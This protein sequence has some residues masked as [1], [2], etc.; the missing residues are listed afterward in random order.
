MTANVPEVK[1]KY[2]YFLQNSVRSVEGQPQNYKLATYTIKYSD[3]SE[4]QIPIHDGVE[5]RKWWTGQWYDNSGAKSWP[6]FVGRNSV[7][8]KYN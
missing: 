5:I 7:S 1:G 6:I 8:M 3:G 4:A 2:V